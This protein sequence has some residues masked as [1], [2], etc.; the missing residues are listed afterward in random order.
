MT[1]SYTVGLSTLGIFTNV[2]ACSVNNFIASETYFHAYPTWNN[3]SASMTITSVANFAIN[4]NYASTRTLSSVSITMSTLFAIGSTLPNLPIFQDLYL[5][6]VEYYVNNIDLGVYYRNQVA[7]VFALISWGFQNSPGI[8]YI[9]KDAITGITQTWIVGNSNNQTVTIT[10][11]NSLSQVEYHT[12]K[13]TTSVADSNL[14]D[15]VQYVYVILKPC[16]ILNCIECTEF[17]SEI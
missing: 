16:T 17:D 8:T 11:P 13:L 2:I 14:V 6:N 10:V 5:G 3:L 1:G 9:F 15:I 12:L 7:N 4:Y